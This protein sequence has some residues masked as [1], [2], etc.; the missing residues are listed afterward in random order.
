[1]TQNPEQAVLSDV[2]RW[3]SRRG[4]TISPYFSWSYDIEAE[5]SVLVW[6][7]SKTV[8]VGGLHAQVSLFRIIQIRN[9]LESY[10]KVLFQDENTIGFQICSIATHQTM[11]LLSQINW[12]RVPIIIGTVLQRQINMNIRYV[13]L[14]M[15]LMAAEAS[16]DSSTLDAAIGGGIGGAAG[17]AIG[18]EIGGR[19]GAIIGGA[20]G[21][22][23]GAALNTEEQPEQA[24]RHRETH[25]RD[26][27]HHRHY[28]DY[29]NNYPY[30]NY[31][32][33]RSVYPQFEYPRS[34][35]CPPGQAKKGRC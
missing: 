22:A 17:S 13:I 1:M 5:G 24:S 32:Y 35:F 3:E 16:A 12:R 34:R 2:I 31:P 14:V 28:Q 30:Y 20:L 26:D 23:V 10:H 21:G 29:G 9:F 27:Y 7:I 15:A 6:G 33:Y 11:R 25:H 18:N 4:P 8:S 19:D